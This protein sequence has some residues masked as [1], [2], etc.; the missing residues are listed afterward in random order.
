MKFI[1]K[2]YMMVLLILSSRALNISNS[3][4]TR[5]TSEASAYLSSTRKLGYSNGYKVFNTQTS[6]PSK[7]LSARI[8]LEDGRDISE[9]IV[10]KSNISTMTTTTTTTTTEKSGYNFYFN[11]QY[12]KE[13]GKFES[14]MQ[15]MDDDDDEKIFSD[16]IKELF[17][18]NKIS[19]DVA[20]LSSVMISQVNHSE[21]S[22]AIDTSSRTTKT[23]TVEFQG[24]SD[25]THLERS[26]RNLGPTPQDVND[27]ALNIERAR[28]LKLDAY[29]LEVKKML[30]LISTLKTNIRRKFMYY[31]KEQE[32]IVYKER[33]NKKIEE[34][35][36]CEK[37]FNEAKQRI[38]AMEFEYNK[39]L[40]YIKQYSQKV[41][42]CKSYIENVK[43]EI[44]TSIESY[45]N[46][47]A[48]N[49]KLIATRKSEKQITRTAIFYW[50]QAAYYYR[51]FNNLLIQNE[52]EVDQKFSLENIKKSTENLSQAFLPWPTN[53]D[54]LKPLD[55]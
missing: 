6:D 3:R 37:N 47:N 25:F 26:K 11:S 13:S 20:K 18:K 5:L 55:S 12:I 45:E 54:F 41:V 50:I 43:I 1:V 49:V 7:I 34:I 21:M 39:R 9:L 48:E 53:L 19:L 33:I 30:T 38:E 42:M 52:T 44:K 17:P 14:F 27:L 10:K 8:K 36:I 2:V 28:K 4:R 22:V 15:G 32:L 35:K 40:E 51:I 23:I 29:K 31:Q 46:T 24:V 16:E